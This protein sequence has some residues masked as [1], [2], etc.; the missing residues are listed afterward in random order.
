MKNNTYAR[1]LILAG[2]LVILNITAHFMPLE[3]AALAPDNYVMLIRSQEESGSFLNYAN[4]PLCYLFLRAQSVLAGDNAGYGFALLLASN[5]LLLISVFLLLNELLQDEVSAFFAG[6]IF[7]LLPNT[8]EIYHTAIY[9]NINFALSAYVLCLLFY[10]KYLSS[11]KASDIAVSLALYATGIFWYEPGFF[12]PLIM[13]IAAL[14]LNR[15][16]ALSCL[17]YLPLSL[18]YAI[19]R[20]TGAFGFAL[21][22]GE[23]HA[24][25]VSVIPFNLL[26][27][28]HHYAGRYMVRSV[29]YGIYKF[30]S[31]EMPWLIFM[32]AAGIAVIMFTVNLIRKQEFPKVRADALVIA[33]AICVSWIA[34]IL[35]NGQGGVGGRHLA[36]PSIGLSVIALWLFS[37]IKRGKPAVAAVIMV[38]LLAVSQGNAWSQAVA[39]RINASVYEYMKEN[40]PQLKE[41]RSVVIDT[42]SFAENI[43]FTLVPQDSNVL[44]TYY[45][46]QAF[47]GWGLKG[48]VKLVTKQ[49]AKD[50]YIA[51]T[52]PSISAGRI[53]FDIPSYV[54]YRHE[55][56]ERV[57]VDAGRCFVIDYDSVYRGGYRNGSRA[58]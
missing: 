24:V 28:L 29:L 55:E 34:P 19:F 26:E 1:K 47:E 54:G 38:V 48:M 44:N 7:C 35:L 5:A 13:F 56:S 23:S 37:M 57:S 21:R 51:K 39:C 20:F 52:R 22:P 46:A 30:R 41:A 33:C 8:L 6:V 36:L 17:M 10:L 9:V 43:P 40:S 31:I 49:N 4:R 32:C 12:T 27:L 14:M 42:R 18:F 58:R 15:K 16:K 50:V 45:G 3:R 53:E 2:V 25:S 11:G